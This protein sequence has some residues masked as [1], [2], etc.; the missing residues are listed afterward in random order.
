M[1]ERDAVYQIMA[2]RIRGGRFSDPFVVAD[3]PNDTDML[4]VV[5]ANSTAVM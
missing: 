3:L 2:C 5:S 1:R 4:S